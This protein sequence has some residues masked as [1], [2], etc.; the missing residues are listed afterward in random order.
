MWESHAN[1]DARM[2][3]KPGPDRALPIYTVDEPGWGT[4]DQMVAAVTTSPTTPDQLETLLRWLLPAPAVPTPPPKLVPS[5]LEQ[6]LQ[7]LLV[8][9]QAPKPVPPAKT[10]I[11][12]IEILLLSLLPGIPASAARMQ[13]G[14]MRRD[15]ATVVC[16]SCSKA[17]HGANRCPE[18]NEAF[19]FMLPGWKAEKIRSGY[20]MISPE[21]QRSI[22][23][24]KSATD[25]RRGVS[26]P[27]Q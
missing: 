23:K 12:N 8:G 25:T 7:R 13:P 10:W 17:D 16:F 14:P 21:W 19:P 26:R 20:V 1:S 6:L 24:R 27:D 9:A 2:F 4:D 3:S 18:L 22:A 15:W 11:T 5:A